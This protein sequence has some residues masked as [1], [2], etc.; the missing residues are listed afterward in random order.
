MQV[1]MGIMHVH[2]NQVWKAAAI[3]H[4]FAV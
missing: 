3:L 4:G 2:T 1:L